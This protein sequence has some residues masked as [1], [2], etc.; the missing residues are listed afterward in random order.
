M[1]FA[2]SF[3]M[4][5]VNCFKIM[6]SNETGSVKLKESS[7]TGSVKNCEGQ[8]DGSRHVRAGPAD[9]LSIMRTKTEYTQE[10]E[11]NER[12]DDGEQ[13]KQ[14]RRADVDPGRILSDWPEL[15]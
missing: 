10:Q 8:R 13:K 5:S 1:K 2:K 7:V 4:S 11:E 14:V 15:C 3:V 9:E 12:D 6:E